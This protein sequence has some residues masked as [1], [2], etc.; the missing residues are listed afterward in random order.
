[1]E[2]ARV[3]LLDAAPGTLLDRELER[4]LGHGLDVTLN[5]RRVADRGTTRAVWGDRIGLTDFDPF[6]E[7]S[8]LAETVRDGLGY[9]ATRSSTGQACRCEGVPVATA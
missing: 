7:S 6:D 2:R 5:L 3:L 4:L 1:M 9:D 8:L